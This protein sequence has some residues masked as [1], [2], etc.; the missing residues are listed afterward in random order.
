MSRRPNL[1]LARSIILVV[2]FLGGGTNDWPIASA[3]RLWARL[4]FP[5]LPPEHSQLRPPSRSCA[6]VNAQMGDVATEALDMVLSRA[7]VNDGLV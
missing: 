7:G 5:C 4:P 2:C 1:D 6:C 3:V